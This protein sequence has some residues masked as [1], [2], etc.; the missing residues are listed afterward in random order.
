MD[1]LQYV[2]FSYM[3]TNDHFRLAKVSRLFKK[4]IECQYISDDNHMEILEWCCGEKTTKEAVKFL[5]R[6]EPCHENFMWELSNDIEMFGELMLEIAK[7][8]RWCDKVWNRFIT[9]IDKLSKYK[10]FFK[11]FFDIITVHLSNADY[12]S[13]ETREVLAY[14]YRRFL[15]EDDWIYYHK[16]LDCW[17]DDYYL[18]IN[19]F[20]ICD[21]RSCPQL[22]Y[23]EFDN[24]ATNTDFDKLRYNLYLFL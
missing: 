9:K 18:E 3:D 11:K 12:I 16:E 2:I 17:Y 5:T 14:V 8:Q 23:V 24:D 6:N 15:C 10:K 7:K 13:D 21:D 22:R 20:V 1:V 19:G 4:I